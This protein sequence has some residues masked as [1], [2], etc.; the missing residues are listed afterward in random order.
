MNWNFARNF[1]KKIELYFQSNSVMNGLKCP[2]SKS[3]SNC[4]TE[5]FPIYQNKHWTIRRQKDRFVNP[6]FHRIM[7][8][9]IWF[10]VILIGQAVTNWPIKASSGHANAST[11]ET[12]PNDPHLSIKTPNCPSL[13]TQEAAQVVS[14]A[15]SKQVV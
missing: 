14:D 3:L 1:V 5:L 4:L 6:S 9:I 11:P 2:K 15:I 7:L 8:N 10:L 13:K 12:L